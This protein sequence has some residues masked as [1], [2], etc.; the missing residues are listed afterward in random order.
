[1]FL[2]QV[3]PLVLESI[4]IAS[5]IEEQGLSAFCFDRLCYEM[6]FLL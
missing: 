2:D 1:M 5:K 3:V 6:A 4:D